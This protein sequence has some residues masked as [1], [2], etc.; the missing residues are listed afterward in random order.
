MALAEW[1]IRPA[2]FG[3]LDERTLD[4]LAS[5]YI[6]RKQWEGQALAVAVWGGLGDTF[7]PAK[8]NGATRTRKP[9]QWVSPDEMIRLMR[10]D[11]GKPA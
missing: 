9:V 2:E 3:D 10:F 1:G 11:P 6:R 5:A 4:R 8:G 7:K